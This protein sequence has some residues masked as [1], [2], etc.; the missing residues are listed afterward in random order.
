MS[1]KSINYTLFSLSFFY[2]LCI[3]YVYYTHIQSIC[4]FVTRSGKTW[5]N[6][7]H[8]EQIPLFTYESTFLLVKLCMRLGV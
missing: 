1:G 8:F 5:I 2:D 3:V 7:I 6:T 4:I